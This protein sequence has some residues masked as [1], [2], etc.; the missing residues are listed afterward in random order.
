VTVFTCLPPGDACAVHI[1]QVNA[2]IN[3]IIATA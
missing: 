1:G 3:K 2:D